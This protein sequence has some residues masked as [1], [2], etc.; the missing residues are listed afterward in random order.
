MSFNGLLWADSGVLGTAKSEKNAELFNKIAKK[1]IASGNNITPT[2]FPYGDKVYL[3][4]GEILQILAIYGNGATSKYT[5]KVKTKNQ[6]IGYLTKDYALDFKPMS[7]MG[8]IASIFLS[9]PYE[10]EGDTQAMDGDISKFQDYIK[11][12]PESKYVPVALIKIASL[13]FYALQADEPRDKKTLR[14]EAIQNAYQKLSKDLQD[15]K[16]KNEAK[17]IADYL[18]INK[19]KLYNHDSLIGE[20]S[21][22]RTKNEKLSVLV[23]DFLSKP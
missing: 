11:K 22:F 12:K 13:H 4:E 20:F 10:Y 1:D 9:M 23:P 6:K 14:I 2:G 21:N 3:N 16:A 15:S 18:T 19:D 5:Y 17:N 8:E 7:E